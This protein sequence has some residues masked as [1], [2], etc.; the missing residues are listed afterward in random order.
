V[1]S[2]L[3][4]LMRGLRAKD[5]EKDADTVTPDDRSAL[6]VARHFDYASGEKNTSYTAVTNYN[7]F[8][9]FGTDKSDPAANAGT[10][11]PHPWQLT[12]KEKWRARKSW[13]LINSSSRSRSRNAYTGCVASKPGRWSSDGLAS[14][15]EI[16][17]KVSNPPREGFQP[18]T[19]V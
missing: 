12:S 8:Y 13:R 19:K 4:W 3:L 2:T 5:H 14:S 15:W 9:E 6:A 11:R 17:P 18:D 10:L 1:G 16:C 7:N